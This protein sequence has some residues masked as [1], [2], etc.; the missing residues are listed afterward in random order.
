MDM[1]GE[2][3]HSLTAYSPGPQ[4]M[5]GQAHMDPLGLVG[6][7]WAEGGHQHQLP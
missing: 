7:N 2:V 5:I 6:H 4:T 1:S 3:P